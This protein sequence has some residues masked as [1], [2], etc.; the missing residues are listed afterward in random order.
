MRILMAVEE[1]G[2]GGLTVDDLRAKVGGPQAVVD[3]LVGELYAIGCLR[4]VREQREVVKRRGLTVYEVGKAQFS[5]YLAK[6]TADHGSSGHT[7]GAVEKSALSAAMQFVR[8]WPAATDI[9]RQ[10]TV[11]ARLLRHLV[12]L[13]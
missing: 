2:V 13:S 5:K 1:E 10:Q 9:G 3:R 11:T 8:A 12:R 6:K 4:R 7:L